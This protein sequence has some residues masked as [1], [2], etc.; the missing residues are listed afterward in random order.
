[1]PRSSSPN[2]CCR[3]L[4]PEIA[5]DAAAIITTTPP[6]HLPPTIESNKRTNARTPDDRRRQDKNAAHPGCVTSMTKETS[7]KGLDARQ[8]KA[9]PVFSLPPSPS[10]KPS[11]RIL[12]TM[13]STATL[14][15]AVTKM[16]G[17]KFSGIS[18]HV[19]SHHIAP[20]SCRTRQQFPSARMISSGISE[21]FYPLSAK[22]ATREGNE[23][24]EGR[25]LLVGPRPSPPRA[26]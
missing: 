14:D 25:Q 16:C 2:E 26:R 23:R 3:A 15:G 24:V 10:K 5:N 12:D 13:L 19:T 4:R 8:K 9:L 1:M 7:M 22:C 21:H 11:S 20:L 18:H 6:R 17:A